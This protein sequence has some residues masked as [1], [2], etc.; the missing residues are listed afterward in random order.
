MMNLPHQEKLN[1]EERRGV[2]EFEFRRACFKPH[3]EVAV[4]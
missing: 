3:R 1:E 2:C 4:P